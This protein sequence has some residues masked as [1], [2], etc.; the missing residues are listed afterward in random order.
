MPEYIAVRPFKY[1]SRMLAPGDRVVISRTFGRVFR[2]QGKVKPVPVAQT[3]EPKPR[4]AVREVEPKGGYRRYEAIPT[5]EEVL[6]ATVA[7]DDMKALRAEYR[8]KF[9]KGPGPS[10][11]AATLREKI[12][13]A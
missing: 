3:E 7:K 12:A 4:K 9:G 2:A 11:D 5:V 6:S 13:A 10:W 8:A 1:N